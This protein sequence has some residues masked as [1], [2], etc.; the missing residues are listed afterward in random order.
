MR[1]MTSGTRKGKEVLAVEKSVD[2]IG[3]N[4][5]KGKEFVAVDIPVDLMGC[6]TEESLAAY[7]TNFAISE[8]D[9][10][11]MGGY[12]PSVDGDR[13][14]DVGNVVMGGNSDDDGF[15]QSRGDFKFLVSTPLRVEERETVPDLKHEGFSMGNMGSLSS[16]Q[17]NDVLVELIR[18]VNA[19]LESHLDRIEDFLVSLDGRLCQM[20]EAFS[21][22]GGDIDCTAMAKRFG[23]QLMQRRLYMRR[24]ASTALVKYV[25]LLHLHGKLYS[26][27]AKMR[28]D[29]AFAYKKGMEW[30]AGKMLLPYKQLCSEKKRRLYKLKRDDVPLQYLMKCLSPKSACLLLEL[31]RVAVSQD[32][33]SLRR[34]ALPLLTA[35]SLVTKVDMEGHP[36]SGPSP[37][38]ASGGPAALLRWRRWPGRRPSPDNDDESPTSLFDSVTVSPSKWGFQPFFTP[39]I[40]NH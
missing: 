8:V 1:V 2:I 7:R 21:R 25:M 6:R 11:E 37:I 3:C 31:R 23:K 22:I 14:G 34:N 16:Q 24:S 5:K 20:S 15:T 28:D 33:A 26:N 19:T 10:A 17:Q 9:S 40:R 12:E 36:T 18:E 35:Y 4:I 29:V 27:F 30:K 39:I 13:D 32:W 38:G